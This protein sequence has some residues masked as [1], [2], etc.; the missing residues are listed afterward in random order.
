MRLS[1]YDLWV[2]SLTND[3]SGRDETIMQ[4]I[5]FHHILARMILTCNLEM[6]RVDSRRSYRT[7]VRLQVYSASFEDE[8][9]KPLRMLTT[10]AKSG[11]QQLVRNSM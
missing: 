5:N 3:Y 1:N 4:G 11:C 10:S 7:L 6:Y 8:I 9:G 2:L